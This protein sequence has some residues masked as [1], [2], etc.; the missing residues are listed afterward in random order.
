[1]SQTVKFTFNGQ[2]HVFRQP[3]MGNRDDISF[4]RIN[5]RSRGGDVIIF[6]DD[7]W[8]KTETLALTFDFDQEVDKN[9]LLYL[10]KISLGEELTYLDHENKLWSGV[11]QNPDTEAVQTGR[12]SF[13]IQVVFEGD[14]V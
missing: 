6:R 10:L 13:I 8:P 3:T 4:Q 7:D 9:R 11:I 5:R 2:D 1:M 12:N 14:M